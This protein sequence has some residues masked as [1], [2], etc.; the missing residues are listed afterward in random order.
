[1]PAECGHEES[2]ALRLDDATSPTH[3]NRGNEGLGLVTTTNLNST[4]KH[5]HEYDDDQDDNIDFGHT[6][7]APC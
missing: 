7:Y 5:L 1:M 3:G 6:Y 4:Q 2:G